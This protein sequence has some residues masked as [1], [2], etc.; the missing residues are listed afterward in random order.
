MQTQ[1]MRKLNYLYERER[2]IRLWAK[3]YCQIKSKVFHN[4][5][6]DW[7]IKRT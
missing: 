4:E 5:K 3:V 2:D 6:K 7:F 1:M